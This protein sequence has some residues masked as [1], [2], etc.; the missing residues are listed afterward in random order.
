MEKKWFQTRWSFLCFSVVK[1]IYVCRYELRSQYLVKKKPVMLVM[2]THSKIR[3]DV[4][5]DKNNDYQR[6]FKTAKHS[7]A[8]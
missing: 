7:S 5:H 6:G 2:K 8:V 3:S 4:D 1:C